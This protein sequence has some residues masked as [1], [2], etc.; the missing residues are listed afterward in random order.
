MTL[1]IHWQLDVAAEP[2]RGEPALR[3]ALP[4]LLRDP[5]Q[6]SQN[7]FDYYAQVAE[8]AAQGRFD[9][10]Y[11][12][13]AA[14]GDDSRIVAAALAREV[15]R[16]AL[17]AGFPASVGS[18]VYA[19]KQAVS[20]QRATGNRL[21]WAIAPDADAATRAGFGDFVPEAQLGQRLEEFLVVARGVHGQHPFSHAGAFFAVEQGGFEAPLNRAAFPPVWLQGE[22][23]EALALS[24]RQADV[25]LFAPTA[26]LAA[27]IEGLDGLAKAAGRQVGFG[28]HQPVLAR[29]STEEALFEAGRSPPPQG[30]LVG[31]YEEVAGQLARR[32]RLGIGQL[33]LSA[34][35]QLEEAYRIGQHLLPRLRALIATPAKA[36]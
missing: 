9:G 13:F 30:A 20:F 15:R 21:G 18:A 1:T 34:G 17:V 10:L 3:P 8:A 5:R 33:V 36:A 25:H 12:P 32:V 7:R 22:S 4:P 16:I 26:D 11:L 23:E 19:A 27:L 14:D 28:L 24:A 29:E 2:A 31:S 35:P 6:T